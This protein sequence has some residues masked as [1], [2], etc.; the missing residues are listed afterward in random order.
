MLTFSVL[1]SGMICPAYL[2]LGELVLDWMLTW[3]S[4]NTLEGNMSF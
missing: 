1:E 2:C 3:D 4:I